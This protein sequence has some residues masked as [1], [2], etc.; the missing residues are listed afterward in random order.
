MTVQPGSIGQPVVP[1]PGQQDMAMVYGQLFVLGFIAWIFW[2][3][4]V[5]SDKPQSRSGFE[6]ER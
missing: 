1:P 5:G 2:T 6:K 3:V 4:F